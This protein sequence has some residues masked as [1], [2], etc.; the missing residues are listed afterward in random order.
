[1]DTVVCV[2]ELSVISVNS[3]CALLLIYHLQTAAAGTETEF[4]CPQDKFRTNNE[5]LSLGAI[6]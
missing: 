3:T 4:Y 5:I 2:F 1:M 6:I